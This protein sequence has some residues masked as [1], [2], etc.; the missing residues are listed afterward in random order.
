MIYYN[1]KDKKIQM[2]SELNLTTIE[3]L[4]VAGNINYQYF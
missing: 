3:S 1:I 4:F 2:Q